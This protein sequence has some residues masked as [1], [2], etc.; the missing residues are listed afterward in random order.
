ML[1]LNAHNRR[2]WLQ[3][4][5]ARCGFY[6]KHVLGQTRLAARLTKINFN[7]PVRARREASSSHKITVIS[8][9]KRCWM[10]SGA[11]VIFIYD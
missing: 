7:L 6:H 9:F 10:R 1:T 2:V 8:V 11:A 3:P 5:V 4:I